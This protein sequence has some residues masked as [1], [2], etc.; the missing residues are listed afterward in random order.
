MAMIKLAQ[1]GDW[2]SL[3]DRPPLEIK[4]SE[5]GFLP[6]DSRKVATEVGDR[7]VHQVRQIE[8]EL[9]RRNFKY[10]H[11]ISCGC[12]ELFGP[13][14]NADSWDRESL[15]RDMATYVKHAKC[16][17]DHRNR[18]DS[19]YFGRPKLAMFDSDRGYGRLLV[20]FHA[21]DEAC[22]DEPLAK[23]AKAE[24]EKL[25]RG[26]EIKVSHGTSIRYDVCSACGNQAKTRKDYCSSRDEGGDCS[27]FGCKTGLSK[28]ANDGRQQ[29]VHNPFNVFFDISTIGLS[30]NSARQADRIAYADAFDLDGVKT[31]ALEESYVLGSAALA[32]RLGIAPR[33]DFLSDDGLTTYQKRL[34]K[35]AAKLVEAEENHLTPYLCDDP[36]LGV[37]SLREVRSFSPELR[38]AAINKL[39]MR[40][41]FFG[42]RIFAKLAGLSG[43]EL[44]AVATASSD[45]L[46]KL[47]SEDRVADLLRL[48]ACVPS[49][50]ASSVQVAASRAAFAPGSLTDSASLDRAKLAAICE[51]PDP[52]PPS[53]ISLETMKIAAEYV[54]TKIVFFDRFW[55]SPLSC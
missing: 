49:M 16:Y 53:A 44:D 11:V 4:I 7:F 51:Q 30:R 36:Q 19:E 6:G 54:A 32:E 1:P 29:Y 20:G 28:F 43:D 9:D 17:R 25:D 27:L 41:E 45:L 31:A 12:E 39:A 5:R 22:G 21:T 15:A 13:N 10:A 24:C 46:V 40:G 3:R 55:R 47:C 34:V 33:L 42:P 18:R 8:K 35:V 14:A 2:V 48:S 37:D 23:I 52:L 26:E 50:Q 38:N